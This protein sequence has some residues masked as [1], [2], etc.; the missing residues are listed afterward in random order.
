[1]AAV[2]RNALV[3]AGV[4]A[5]DLDHVNA[6]ALGTRAD[7]VWEARSLAEALAD[8]NMPVVAFKS[9]FGNLGAG[10]A[11]TELAASLLALADGVLLPTLNHER[12]DPACPVR[13]LRTPRPV[14]RACFLKIACTE[15]GQC[16][17]VVLRRWQ[18]GDA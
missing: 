10:G 4:A 6:H 15:L 1:L 2:I 7:D 8:R 18:G 3:S 9:Y 11:M 5:R 16:A 17:A 12:T 14:E 13:V